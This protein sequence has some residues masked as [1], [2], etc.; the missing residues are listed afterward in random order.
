MANFM[1]VLAARQWYEERVP[2]ETHGNPIEYVVYTSDAAH[3][4]ITQAVSMC[5]IGRRRSTPPGHRTGGIRKIPVTCEQRMNCILLE[6]EI[7]AD[8]SAGFVWTYT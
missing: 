2:E 8:L 4:C 1:S 7:N 5:G 6:E 3:R